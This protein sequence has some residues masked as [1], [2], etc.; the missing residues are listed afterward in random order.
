ME[1]SPYFIVPLALLAPAGLHG[2]GRCV[3]REGQVDV[4]LELSCVQ[5]ALPV[6]AGVVELEESELAGSV[7]VEKAMQIKHVV[8]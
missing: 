5:A 1:I 6:L 7:A 8:P 4:G 3:H 2:L